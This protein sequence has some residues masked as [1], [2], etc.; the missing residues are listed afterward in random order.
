MKITSSAVRNYQFTIVVF[1][2][3]V[4]LGISSFR[5]MPRSED[6]ALRVP[7]FNVVV[8]YPGANS[9]DME[10]LV[11]KPLEDRLKELDDIHKV[12]TTIRDG[13]A[14]IGIDFFYGTDPDKKYDDVLRQVNVGRAD[15]PADILS[16][17]VFKIQTIDVA[18]MQIAL[19]SEEA[20]YARLQDLAEDLKKEIERVP[21]IRKAEKHAFPEKQ[22]RVSLD[23]DNLAR[24]AIPLDRVV[25][26]IRA[27]NTNIPGG[28]VELGARRFNLKT[29]GNYSSIDD[30]RMTPL[31]G[32]GK[33]VVYL[34]DV[35]EVEWG[36]ED[37]EVFGRFNGQRAV[38]VTAKP[39]NNINIFDTRDGLRSVINLFR[40]RLPGDVKIEAAF[41][42]SVNVERRL[43][44]LGED[45]LIALA[46]VLITVLPLGLRAS[47][48]VMIAIPLSL[49]M[50]MTLLYFS[51]YGLNQLSIV[52]CVIALGLL[53]DDSIVVVENIARFR[54]MGVPPIEA[55]IKA[56]D[57]IAVAVVGTTAALLFAFLPLMMLPGGPGQFIRS[58]PVAVVYTVL[59]SMIVALTIIPFLGSRLLSAKVNPE[60][61]ILLRLLHRA[62]E[63]SYR[64]ILHRCMQHRV[65][66]LF[67]A[68]ILFGLS[69]MLLKP[70]GFSLFPPAGTAEFLIKIDAE[71][72][73]STAETDAIAGKV[74]RV[75]AAND[76]IEW[77]F[78]TV[79]KGNPQVYYNE[80]PLG[81]KANKAEIFTRLKEFDS[82][83]SPELLEKLR[84]QLNAITGAHINVKEFE[85]GPPIEAPIAVR[86][87]SENLQTL[88]DLS[89]KVE[90]VLREIE[91]TR[92]INNPQRVQRTDLKLIV[93]KSTAAML[94][95]P[96]AEIDRAVRLAFAG[97]NVSRFRESDGDE[98]NIQLA[99]PRGERASLDNW[100][101]IQVLSGS[102][103]YVP[104]SEVAELEFTSAPPVIQRFNRERS[105]TITSYA[106]SGY[107]VDKL[108]KQTEARLLK[109]NWPPGARWAFGGEVESRKES[110]GDLTSAILIAMFGILAILVLE[111]KSFRGTII[112][113]SVIPLG[114]IGGL[115]ALYLTGY[116]LSF[117]ATVGFVALIGIEIKNSILLVDFTNQLRATGTPLKE[118]IEQAGEIRFL[119]VVLTTLTAVGALMPLAVQ[120][121]GLYSPLAIVIIGGLI[122]SLLLSRLVTPVMYSLIPPPQ[123]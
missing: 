29:S 82:K 90:G 14:I 8:I 94:G 72:G 113:A 13:V 122:S 49:A 39:R 65:I 68:A 7:S 76:Q 41:D 92:D 26:A 36:Y 63:L 97:L 28:S 96:N 34:K 25:A 52:G 86:V 62:I 105:T 79:G 91:G 77:Y 48:L 44:R 116:S 99:L 45:F 104:I 35:A 50:G 74:E 80:V 3:L 58:M 5:N 83:R 117:T 32:S 37:K 31:A 12:Y 46:L 47:F 108:T 2:C 107:N 27:S 11:A 101:R 24:L 23:L 100:K 66:T 69:L 4:V 18:L 40:N 33:A 20:S 102:G 115:C 19:V 56:T 71:E 73:A 84:T 1:L 118:A 93:N 106:R 55:A 70:I 95:V 30:V 103:A 85:Q 121:S 6:P 61:N 17:D 112:V 43:G 64:P 110:F 22:V 123:K 120:K 114:V 21:G 119:P 75:L 109:L 53:V 60:G 81:Q 15:L 51:G 111:F 54:R 67:V 57:Q 9:V 78:T 89:A 87:F 38:F 59:S 88:A 10:R 42:Q 98:Y 16:S